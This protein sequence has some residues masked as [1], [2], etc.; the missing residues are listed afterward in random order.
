MLRACA[1]LAPGVALVVGLASAACAGPPT[2]QLKTQIDR[3]LAVLQE[4]ALKGAEH[5][6]KRQTVIRDA[7]DAA[8]DFTEVS[9]RALGAAWAARTPAERQEFVSGFTA[10]LQRV[11]LGR[12]DRYDDE[13][14]LYDDE[15]VEDDLATVTARVE[16][17][18]GDRMP[19]AFKMLRG[20]DDRWRVYDV[21][22][23]GVSLLDNYRAQFR[24]VLRRS[25][26]EDLVKRIK[27][28]GSG[29]K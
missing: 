8:I 21:S 23:D 10:F 7:M 25:S 11:Y 3:V 17:K 26:Y 15:R 12:I 20:A 6:A 22:T 5:R 4:P 24:T 19:L 16:W 18:D 13:K 28:Q 14:L 9:R 2:E 27:S 29:Q 1:R